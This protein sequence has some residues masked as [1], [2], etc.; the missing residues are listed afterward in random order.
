MVEFIVGLGV[1][2]QTEHLDW[3]G[4]VREKSREKM[5]R[6]CSLAGQDCASQP[7]HVEVAIASPAGQ[8]HH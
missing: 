4:V 3:C 2:L 5:S 8:I 7:L 1:C 6:L